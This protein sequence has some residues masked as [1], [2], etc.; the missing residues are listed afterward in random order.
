MTRPLNKDVRPREYLTESEI[1]IL[2]KAAKTSGRHG[3]RDSMLILVGFIHGLRVSELI[4]LKWSQI[5][6][7][8]QTIYITRLK[9]GKKSIHPITKKEIIGLRKLKNKDQKSKY[10]FISEYKTPISRSTFNKIIKRAAEKAAIDFPVHPHM[11]RH[12]VGF[13]LANDGQDTRR[14][15][16]YLG[17]KNIQHTTLYTELNSKKFDNFWT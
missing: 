4:N 2:I 3:L 9:N 15:Q 17:H 1:N 10:V 8:E 12:A 11:L 7:D 5:N 6:F 14:I 13:K 16:D